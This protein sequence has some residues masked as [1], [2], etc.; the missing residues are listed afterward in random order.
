MDKAKLFGNPTTDE[1][2]R[3]GMRCR[4]C[5]NE[6]LEDDTIVGWRSGIWHK[7]CQVA[8][9]DSEWREKDCQTK[10]YLL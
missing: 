8:A 5:S 2:W 1:E 4:K 9:L 3:E 6:I 7:G 10:P